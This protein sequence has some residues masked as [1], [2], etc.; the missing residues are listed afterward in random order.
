VGKASERQVRKW[1][2]NEPRIVI[3]AGEHRSKPALVDPY[4]PLP[5]PVRPSP[6]VVHGTSPSDRLTRYAQALV[7]YEGD[8]V[9]ALA[10]VFSLSEDEVLA[11]MP[12]L[13]EQL[14]GGVGSLHDSLVKNDLAVENQ[15]SILRHWAYS[16][17]PGPSLKAIEIVRRIVEDAQSTHEGLTAEDVI[18]MALATQDGQVDER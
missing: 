7:A 1:E 5:G 2:A 13:R 3:D 6:T 9:K 4:M 12:A 11:Q 17:S 16:G 10:K 14:Q 18:R 8:S 15:L